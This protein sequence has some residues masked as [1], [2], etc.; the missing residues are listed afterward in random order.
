MWDLFLAMIQSCKGDEEG[1][2]DQYGSGFGS[3]HVYVICVALKNYV[4]RDPDGMMKVAK[5]RY[6]SHL[7]IYLDFVAGLLKRNRD[8]DELADGISILGLLIALLDNMPGKI[9][10]HIPSLLTMLIT[11]F[12]YLKR[13]PEVQKEDGKFYK[14]MLFQVFSMLLAYNCQMVISW[15]EGRGVSYHM[16]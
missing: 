15:L 3:E 16:F 13:N 9:D 7:I 2:D 11:E 5:G 1:I 14:Q 6:K 10:N 12:N 4:C 8:Q